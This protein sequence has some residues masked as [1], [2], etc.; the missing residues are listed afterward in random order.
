VPF[1]AT[2]ITARVVL[3][4]HGQSRATVDRVAGGER[5]CRGLSELGRR[6]ARALGDRLSGSGELAATTAL[7]A[8]TLPRAVE[9]A[10]LIAP[11]LGGLPVERERELCE[12]EPGEGDGLTW[13]VWGKRY[14]GFDMAAE[15]FRPLS[16]G[17]ESW[18]EFGLR[19]GRALSRVAG[20]F[21]GTTVV[22]ACHG[23]IIEQSMLNGLHLPAQRPP[24]RRLE[25]APNT[26]LTEWLVDLVPGRAQH[27]RLVRFADAAH[28]RADGEPRGLGG[29][30]PV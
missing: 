29:P 25:T 23:G 3:V 21:V 7:L 22:V 13:D 5:G 20:R 10:E 30:R 18:A 27:W 15:P 9:T 1:A 28:L 4:R 11:A 26:S 14:E 24:G 16:P 12:L 2:S 8:S 6:Q 17:G 19:A